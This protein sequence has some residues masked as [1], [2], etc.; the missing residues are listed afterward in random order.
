[1]IAAKNVECARVSLLRTKAFTEL[2]FVVTLNS[3]Y[4]LRGARPL[5][6]EVSSMFTYTTDSSRSA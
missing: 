6:I 2:R 1:M 4:P 5:A 3:R